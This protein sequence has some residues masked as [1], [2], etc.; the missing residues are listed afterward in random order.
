MF[1]NILHRDFPNVVHQVNKK[2]EES[3]PKHRLTDYSQIEAIIASFKRIKNID[4]SFK[5]EREYMLKHVTK[6]REL[7]IAIVILFYHPEKL[8]GLS[9][10]R[11]SF[12]HILSKTIKLPKSSISRT[13]CNA[14]FAFKTYAEFRAEVY[15]TYERIK[16]ENQFFK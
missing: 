11:N 14:I 3:I 5:N 16:E 15:E 4:D 13:T 8:L 2:I 6:Q 1:L 9:N 10:K 12:C 7:A